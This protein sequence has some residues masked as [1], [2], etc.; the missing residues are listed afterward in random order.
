MK[1]PWEIRRIFHGFAV[2]PC[3][4]FYIFGTGAC[5]AISFSACSSCQNDAGI[6]ALHEAAFSCAYGCCVLRVSRPILCLN[7]YVM[8]LMLLTAC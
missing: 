4:V 6:R 1:K 5:V 2:L 3:S 8:V 7:V